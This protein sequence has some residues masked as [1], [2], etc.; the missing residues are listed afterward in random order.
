MPF[1]SFPRGRGN[2]GKRCLRRE[3]KTSSGEQTAAQGRQFECGQGRSRCCRW[4]GGAEPREEGTLGKGKD[5]HEGGLRAHA[6]LLTVQVLFST[7][8]ILGKIA[9]RIVPSGALVGM[10]VAGAALAFAAL[11][12]FAGGSCSVSRRDLGWLAASSF[13]GVVVNQFL[14]M[15]GLALTTVVNASLIST[16]IPVF[17]VLV[18]V[19][20]GQDRFSRRKMFGALL[21]GA[22][23]LYLL[24]LRRVDLSPATTLGNTLI[25]INSF[26]YA[27]YL[28][29]SKSLL[30]KHGTAAVLSWTFGLGCL[31]A[32][33][34][35]A[36]SLSQCE[37]GSVGTW[38]WLAVAYIVVVPTVGGYYLG[39]WALARV[40]ASTAAV[41]SYLQPVI[42]LSLAPW[43]L[44]EPWNSRTWGAAAFILSGVACVTWGAR[45]SATPE[46]PA[47]PDP[48]GS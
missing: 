40:P 2:E 38:V 20:A 11:Q 46:I 4:A 15:K 42:A 44:G 9:L 13:L 28:V 16:T 27:A 1:P 36:Y 24:D 30:R 22:G 18:G 45:P 7:W 39:A 34:V 3:T 35:G 8:P 17:A 12:R 19:V 10:R 25:F 26:C 23:V 21:A 6:A 37:L 47:C 29:L 48:L 33:P 41:Y 14:F 32:I 43:I 31:A 5:E